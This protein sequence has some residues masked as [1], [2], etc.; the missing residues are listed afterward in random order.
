MFEAKGMGDIRGVRFTDVNGDFRDDWTWIS[1]NGQVTTWVNQRGEEKGMVPRWL[2][3]GVTH[4]GGFNVY[5]G[6]SRNNIQ[7]GRVFGSGRRD[8]A[9]IE[10]IN[11]RDS[12]A[13]HGCDVNVVVFQ[14]LGSGGRFQK[15]E[16]RPN[17]SMAIFACENRFN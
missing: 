10:R 9:H 7:F 12:D 17:R 4:A 13:G 3:A 11:C 16:I 14:N 8:Y 6:E 1:T 2:A 15:G 5:D